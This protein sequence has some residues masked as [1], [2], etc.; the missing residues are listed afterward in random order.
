MIGCISVIFSCSDF[1]D[2]DAPKDQVDTKVVFNDDNTAI[3]AMNSVYIGLL[4]EGFLGGNISSNVFL[5]SC[6]TDELIVT[7]SQD[8]DVRYF[9]ELNVQ[10]DNKA[11]RELW[12]SSYQQ[13]YKVNAILEGLNNSVGVT[14]SVKEQIR[15][16]ALA[17]RALLHFY[18]TQTFGNVPYVT[19]IDYNINKRIEKFESAIIMQNAINDLLEAEELLKPLNITSERIR[20]NRD[21]VEGFLARMYLYQENWPLA[22]EYAERL[23]NNHT[24]ELESLE[25]VFLKE[26][27]SA[28][29]QL[30]PLTTGF[31]TYDAMFHIFSFVPAPFVKLNLELVNAFEL[32]D[33]RKLNWIKS[34]GSSN[35]NFHAYKYKSVGSTSPSKEYSMI[36]RIEEM[37]LIAA[38]ATAEQQNWSIS[39]VYVNTIRERANLSNVNF[40][41]LNEA[42]TVIL[43]ER[44]VEFFCEL[45]HRFYDLKRKNHLD[46]LTAN[47]PNW[48]P[49]LNVLPI[50]QSE[51]IL[52]PNLLP[53]NTGY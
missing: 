7:T 40:Q 48:Q 12:N 34:V 23:I 11:I 49:H 2:I 16:E 37:Y 51:L 21:V 6:Y 29:W 36:L 3:A 10:A 35:E 27:K 13:I 5:M 41:S 22:Q 19:T 38:E 53:Q 8:L 44:R 15:G 9:Y 46:D 25:N 42:T 32:D 20:I 43:Q 26:S 1:L 52:N 17:V 45:G 18:L 28:I 33:Q 24:Y 30:K 4:N 14:D 47:K 31:N 50:P 39:N